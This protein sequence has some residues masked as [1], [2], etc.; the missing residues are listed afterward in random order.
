MPAR[1]TAARV[2][3]IVAVMLSAVCLLVFCGEKIEAQ[4]ATALLTGTIKDSTGAV[5]PDAKV[6]LKNSDTNIARTANSDK[7]GEFLF[8]L[9]PIG[10]YEVDVEGASFRKYVRKGITLE[11]NQ[12]ARLDVVLEVGAA[13]QVIEVTGDVT[14]VDTVSD[15]IGTSVVGETIQRAPLNGR[16]VLDLALLQPGVT[17][18][19]GD[20]TAAGTYSIAGGRTDSVTFLLDGGLNNNLLDNSVVYNPNPDTIA[21]FR[22]LESNYS[23]EYGRNGGGVISVVTKSGTNDWHGSAFEF[24]RNNDLNANSFFNKSDPANPLLRNVLK[25][26]QFGGTF[27]GPITIPKVVHGKD[28]FFFFVGYQ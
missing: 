15:T 12:N 28:R 8:T 5:V 19:N 27:G 25:R 13:T 9:I 22:I 23:A 24:L 2:F 20:S 18:T 7:S 11:I 1:E 6:T 14:Q 4:Q 26:N 3:R 16:N 17:E 21:E 10:R